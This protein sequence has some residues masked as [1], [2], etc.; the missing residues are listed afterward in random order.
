MVENIA[1]KI[2]KTINK[3]PKLTA[4]M[5][6][7]A[8]KVSSCPGEKIYTEADKL[9]NGIFAVYNKYKFNLPVLGY[10][11]Y[12]IE[13]E[14]LGQKVVFIKSGS[15][16]LDQKNFLIKSRKDLKNI[17]FDKSKRNSSRISY[18]LSAIEL[19][20]EK[21]GIT[22]P[23]QYT[24]PFSLAAQIFGME[25]L[26]TN[27]FENP[28]FVKDILQKVTCDVIIPWISLQQEK[29]PEA[30]LVLGADALA[31]PPNLNLGMIQE[32]VIP[33]I[34][35]I[36]KACGNKTGVVNWWGDSYFKNPADFFE[37][38]KIVSPNNSIL[39]IQDPDLAK[40]NLANVVDYASK[41][42]LSLTF[43]LGASFLTLHSLAEINK[44]VTKYVTQ[45][46]N[47]ADFT[48][49]FCNISSDTPEEKIYQAIKTAR[50]VGK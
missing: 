8:I 25:R 15:P 39:R 34:K 50:D 33:Y 37:L 38:K 16:K 44:R 11:V 35:K 36:K 21:T 43:G 17:K 4:Q 14:A 18:V 23:L 22:P 1:D 28:D 9:V 20:I 40:I 29:F 49:Y 32:F 10:D 3:T 31:S 41:N 6:E 26:L 47:N 24:A 5:H 13:A 45:G 27:I 19:Y 12:N 7:H 2:K 48:L 46:K 42:K 30:N